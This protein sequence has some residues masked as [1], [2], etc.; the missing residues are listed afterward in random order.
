MSKRF[1][2]T[3]LII[4][5]FPVFWFP[6]VVNWI[7]E[8]LFLVETIDGAR[9]LTPW[10]WALSTIVV[11][12]VIIVQI[13]NFYKSNNIDYDALEHNYKI[14]GKVADSLMLICKDKYKKTIDYISRHD[15]KKASFYDVHDPTSSINKILEEVANLFESFA[16]VRSNNLGVTLAYKLRDEDEW[17]WF[18]NSNI[19]DGLS[20]EA[21]TGNPRSTLYQ[22][23][24]GKYN[25]RFFPSKKAAFESG[26][27]VYDKKDEEN[28]NIGSVICANV[29]CGNHKREYVSAAINISIYGAEILTDPRNKKSVEKIIRENILD[30]YFIRIKMELALLY[31]KHLVK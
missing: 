27:Y 4:T 6:F 2:I 20:L 23:I 10:G 25:W 19:E 7:G 12:S 28:N 3:H 30:Q 21:L 31:A 29:S 15:V 16:S 9:A 24:S 13:I 1:R 26:E 5:L 22:I 14:Y 8:P 17:K 18:D 11:L